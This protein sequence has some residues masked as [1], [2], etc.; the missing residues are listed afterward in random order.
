MRH[1]S[2]SLVEYSCSIQNG[3][4]SYSVDTSLAVVQSTFFSPSGS[5]H[6]PHTIVGILGTMEG[7][8]ES[9]FLKPSSFTNYTLLTFRS[10]YEYVLSEYTI[11]WCLTRSIVAS[12]SVRTILTCF[13]FF[14]L[15]RKQPQLHLLR[16]PPRRPPA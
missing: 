8:R 1:A 3:M 13:N 5:V 14:S 15:K 2:F 10:S 11:S 4:I 16:P 6:A 7:K 9:L 12:Q